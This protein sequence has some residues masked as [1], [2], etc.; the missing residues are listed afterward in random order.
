MA[1]EDL[2]FDEGHCWVREDGEEL[3]IGITE[4]AQDELG[5]VIFVEL[6][7]V[8]AETARGEAFGSI[9]SAKAVEDLIAP[10]NGTV[11]RRNDDAVDVP[12]TV[13]EDP[14]GGGWLIAVKPKEDYA[15]DELL[16]YEQY[17]ATL[18]IEEEEEEEM[19]DLDLEED[20]DLL[21]DEDE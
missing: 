11:T 19:E 16:T 17:L 12:E 3:V 6:P 9:E 10:V 13:N 1:L 2:R 5:E 8:G 21:F 15:P 18:D 7:E 20:E 14:Y 4:Y